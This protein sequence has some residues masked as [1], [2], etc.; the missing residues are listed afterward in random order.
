MPN[1]VMGPKGP[2]LMTTYKAGAAIV[3]N[4]F[5]KRGA[6]QDSVIPATDISVNLGV[7]YDNQDV[8]GRDVP[9]AHRSGETVLIEA[10]AAVALD[11][12]L[13][14]DATAR[15]VAAAATNPYS[16]VARQ[17]ATAA[18]ELIVCEL[19]GPGMLA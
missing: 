14:S 12:K 6:D 13:K 7:A 19:V 16:A 10:G 8:I 1:P 4:R 9:V 11:A 2:L 3:K 15:A 5:V 18:G 17:A